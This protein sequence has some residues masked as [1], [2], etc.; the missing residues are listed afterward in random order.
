[1]NSF[2]LRCCKTLR[3]STFGVTIVLLHTEY[4]RKRGERLAYKV[5]SKNLF[6]KRTLN[7]TM[8]ILTVYDQ[9]ISI[10]HLKNWKL[11]SSFCISQSNLHYTVTDPED[12]LDFL[13]HVVNCRA[14]TN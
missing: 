14:L 6:K 8:L 7:K 9:E 5:Q 13:K 10:W 3:C 4:T 2:S 1:M 12:F 11:L